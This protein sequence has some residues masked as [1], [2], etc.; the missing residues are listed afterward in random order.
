LAHPDIDGLL[1]ALLPFAQQMLAKHGEYFPFGGTMSTDGEITMVGADLSEEQPTSQEV[2]GLLIAGLREEAAPGKLRA[3]AV[4]F[5][6]SITPPGQSREIDAIKV[7]LEHVD[8]EATD[9]FL[10]YRKNLFGKYR[11]GELVATRGEDVI[12]GQD[13]GD[14]GNGGSRG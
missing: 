9:V 5:N 13:G 12:L 2:L 4:C 10:P 8:V 7:H 6:A 14:G 11:F 3:A 1:N